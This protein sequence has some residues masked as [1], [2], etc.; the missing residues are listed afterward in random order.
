MCESVA[1]L[2]K[3]GKEEPILNGIEILENKDGH[4]RI[5]NLFGEERIIKARLK[6]FSLVDHKIVLESF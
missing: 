1:Y 2:L 4:I 3:D 5:V 6:Y